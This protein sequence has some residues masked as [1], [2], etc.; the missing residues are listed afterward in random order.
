MRAEEHDRA[1]EQSMMPGR[2][3]IAHRRRE[4]LDDGIDDGGHDDAPARHRRW[5]ARHHDAAFRDDHLERPERAFVDW[6]ERASERLV[7]DARAR[8]RA[9]VDAGAA[10]G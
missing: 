5:K 6:L 8:Q 3:L 2:H 10:L 7:G 1:A 9:R 4:C